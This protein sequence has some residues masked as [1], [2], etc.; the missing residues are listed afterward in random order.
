MPVFTSSIV[1]YAY[2]TIGMKDMVIAPLI[3][4][5]PMSEG[6][7]YS[8]GSI[9]KL[10]GSIDATISIGRS[11]D[12]VTQAFDDRVESFT[13]FTPPPDITFRTKLAGL[14]HDIQ[15][16]IFGNE[17]REET[18]IL[19]RKYNDTPRYFAV[20]FRAELATKRTR[21]YRYVWLLKVQARVA[22]E[23]FGTRAGNDITRQTPEVEWR[24]LPRQCDGQYQV[25][26]DGYEDDKSF[27]DSVPDPLSGNLRHALDGM[28]MNVDGLAPATN[29]LTPTY[30]P[31]IY[32]Y[33]AT[34]PAFPN[35]CYVGA[36]LRLNWSGF[37]TMDP[38]NLRKSAQVIVNGVRYP[39]APDGSWRYGGLCNFNVKIGETNT[40]KVLYDR[41]GIISTYTITASPP[42]SD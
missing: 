12:A 13:A 38:P 9:E 30:R 3:K 20:G 2:G 29:L 27:L 8:Y 31:N 23:S 24:V 32:S 41:G 33:T 28:Q 17:Y 18:R 42:S 10:Y 34:I 19:Y 36:Y 5:E 6:G 39:V 16:W 37:S 14:P 15:W 35:K 22:N 26:M 1:P 7:E 25:E 21:M 40:I 4:D 11:Y